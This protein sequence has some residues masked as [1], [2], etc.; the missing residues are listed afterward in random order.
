MI[1]E[2]MGVRI[3]ERKIQSLI[4]EITELAPIFRLVSSH[5]LLQI[6]NLGSGK[7]NIRGNI[8]PISTTNGNCAKYANHSMEAKERS[9]FSTKSILSSSSRVLTSQLTSPSS[10][11]CS[12]KRNF[13]LESF[14]RV[15]NREKVC[16]TVFGWVA[17]PFG[18]TE[19]RWSPRKLDTT[20][21][22]ENILHFSSV[23]AI[24]M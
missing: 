3:K 18:I 13:C 16:N 7:K 4:L 5:Y 10:L 1:P 2:Q 8:F 14:F 17:Q 12:Y 15:P 21:E 19:A 24:H 11:A 22:I 23:Q 6:Q 9:K 20:S